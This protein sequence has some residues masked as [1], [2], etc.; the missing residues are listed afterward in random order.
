MVFKLNTDAVMKLATGKKVLIL[1]GINVAIVAAIYW[2][3]TAP[4][5]E[6]ITK[7]KSE[8][9]QLINKLN[10]SRMIASDIPKYRAQKVELEKK[11]KNAVAQLPNQKEIPDLIDSIS[12]VGEKAGLT[13]LLF[14]PGREVNKGFYANIPIKMAVEG[15]Y[16]S[17]YD[18]S[19]K[20]GALPR[21]VNLS[22]MKITSVGHQERIPILKATFTATTF[23]FVKAKPGGKPGKKKPK[24]RK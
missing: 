17:L 23:R 18:F 19:K 24:K 3:M 11:L 20:I 13:L 10:E 8:Y 12:D 1:V 2:F 9:A 4:K 22:G 7:L 14:K 15:R 5:Y 6:E 16:E 21:I